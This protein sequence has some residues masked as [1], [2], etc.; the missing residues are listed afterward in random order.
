MQTKTPT[1]EEI[2]RLFGDIDDHRAVEI[3]GL[4]P[5]PEELEEVAAYLAGMTEVMS[6]ERHPL[7]G[8]VARI[9]EIITRDEIRNEDEHR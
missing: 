3:I 6:E 9:H 7:A 4:N 2:I 1:H 5:T 8:T